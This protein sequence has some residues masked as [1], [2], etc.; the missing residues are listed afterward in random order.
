MGWNSSRL[1]C[2]LGLEKAR[3]LRFAILAPVKFR[4]RQMDVFRAVML[5]GSINGAAKMLFVSQTGKS[6]V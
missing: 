2:K 5:T 3:Y 6:V 4:L 1:L